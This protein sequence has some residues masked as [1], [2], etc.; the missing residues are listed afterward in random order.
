MKKR[1]WAFSI[2]AVILLAVFLVPSLLTSQSKVMDKPSKED[3]AHKMQS[4]QIPFVANNG[5]VDAQVKF[6]ANTFGGTVF[7]TKEGEIVYALPNNNSESGVESLESDG[8]R[9]RSEA[10][11]QECRGELNSPSGISPLERGTHP[12]IPSREGNG[13]CNT[14]PI[15]HDRNETHPRPLPYRSMGQALLEGRSGVALKEQFVGAKTRTI[16]GEEKSVTKVNYFKGNDSSKWKSNISTYDVVNLGEIYKG[17]ELRLKAYGNNVEKL[18]CVKPDA[19]PDQIKISLSGISPSENPP[20]LSPSVSGTGVCPPLAGAGG[21]MGARGLWVNEHGELVAETELGAVKFTKP[22]AYQEINGKRVDVECKYTIA[23]CGMQN[24]EC[25]TNLKSEFQYPNSENPKSSIQNVDAEISNPKS[26][27][28]NPKLQ[29]GFKVASYDRTK[30]LIIDPLLAST[31]LGGSEDQDYGYSLALDTSGNVYVAGN[32]GSSDFPT[33][34]LAYDTSKNGGYDVFV[35][36]LNSG[37]TS[38]LASTYLGGSEWDLGNSL[39]L[40]TSGNVY[41]TGWTLSSDFPT[42]IGAY[43]TSYGGDGDVFVSKLNTELTSL[44]ASTYLGGSSYDYGRSLTLD[45]S[46]NVYVAG[47]TGSSGFPTTIVAYDTSYNGGGSDVFVSKLDSGLTSLLASTFLG[48]SGSSEDGNSLTLDTSGNVYVTG[49]TQSSDF[50]ITS[51]AYDISYNGS[52]DVFVSKLN[53]GLTSLLAST[54]L[55]G[56]GEDDGHSLALDTSGNVHV[57]GYTSSSSFPTTSGA[58]DT[59][60][61]TSNDVFVSKLDGGLTSLLAS[62]YLGGSSYDYGRSL[63]LDTSGNVY[64]AGYTGSSDFPTTSGAYDTSYGGDGDVFVSKL[65]SGLTSML[66]STYLGGSGSELGS[67]LTLDTSGNVH[68]TGYTSSSSFPTTSGAYDTSYGGSKNVFVSKLDS[69]LTASTTFTPIPTPPPVSS[70]SPLPTLPP[71]PTPIPSPSLSKEC[72]VSGYVSNQNNNLLEYVT[73]TIT[74]IDFSDSTSSDEDGYYLF[75]RLIAGEY[76]LTYEKEGYITKTREISLIEGEEKYLAVTVLIE[77]MQNGRISGYV[78]N[79]K[80][81]PIES[82]KIR[83]KRANSRVL[84][85][86]FSDEDGFFEFADLDAD[87]YIITALKS[88]Y[89]MVKQTITLEEGEEV[90]IEIEIKKTGRKIK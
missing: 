62:T 5:Q 82:A 90:D 21:G 17:I 54:Y 65:N 73:I 4:I 86:T 51:G 32:T 12:L 81:N 2:P 13:V 30:D 79:M 66:A 29:Y 57:T 68:V 45:T 58:Y 78:Y 25:K 6:Y 10:R 15:S 7:V 8:R 48:G 52:F 14:T 74:S 9:H 76:T 75:S 36:K 40:D 31:Y 11:I 71:L 34:I 56:K 77:Q 88:G 85:K 27:I 61:G 67:S 38:L 41:V 22:I 72:I 42:T 46:G 23:D 44:L 83:L 87:T 28:H 26:A 80:G 50:P 19:N 84:K 63:T 37:L 35:S 18:F 60:Y 33:T 39:T 20:P 64:V 70:P 55:G 1:I 89:K 49:S 3:V 43:D 53:G 24:A 47:H 16:Q 59:S 69:D